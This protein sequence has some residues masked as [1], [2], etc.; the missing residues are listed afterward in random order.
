MNQDHVA[1]LQKARVKLVEQRRVLVLRDGSTDRAEGYAERIVT[2]QAAIA[3]T[4]SA[5]ADEQR[6]ANAAV[7]QSAV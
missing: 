6:L 3:S 1:A 7:D 4:D 2:I 5:I